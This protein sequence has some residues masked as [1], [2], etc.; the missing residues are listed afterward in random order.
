MGASVSRPASRITAEREA[1]LRFFAA[2]PSTQLALREHLGITSTLATAR[3]GNAI[4]ACELRRVM[5]RPGQPMTPAVYE[6][7][8]KGRAALNAI[9]NPPAAVP[10]PAPAKKVLPTHAKKLKAGAG[11]TPR[12]LAVSMEEERRRDISHECFSIELL[13][14]LLGATPR[15]MIHRARRGAPGGRH[16]IPMQ[17]FPVAAGRDPCPRCGTRGDLGCAHQRPAETVMPDHFVAPV[18][19][20][21]QSAGRLGHHRRKMSTGTGVYHG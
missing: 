11:Q 8:E 2:A 15:G 18:D 5:P 3:I 20:R 19:G 7:T 21:Q 12:E 1:V 6:I 10:V 4:G 17:S 16:S 14:K 9:D 13:N